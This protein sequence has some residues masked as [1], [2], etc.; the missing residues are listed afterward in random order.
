MS[1]ADYIDMVTAHAQMMRRSIKEPAAD[2]LTLWSLENAHRG[3][4]M[5]YYDA[6]EMDKTL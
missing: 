4:L 5:R 2:T 1:N 6:Q 3:V